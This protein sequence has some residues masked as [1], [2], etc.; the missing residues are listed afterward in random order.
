MDLKCTGGKTCQNGQ[1]TCPSGQTDCSGTC[2]NLDTDPLN[3][4]H[5]GTV[6]TGGKTC[7]NGQCT[8]PTTVTPGGSC[9]CTYSIYCDGTGLAPQAGST[10]F[11]A[12]SFTACLLDCDNSI[13]CG[14]FTYE[15]TT[16][17]CTQFDAP[18]TVV[19][20]PGFSAGSI[21]LGSC[22]GRCTEF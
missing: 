2:K 21:I 6:C 20:A 1:C 17:L 12:P 14:S 22:T 3:C 11:T 4:G 18:G 15:E 5:C 9:G 19:A 7:Q 10:T 16:G 13:V 8:C